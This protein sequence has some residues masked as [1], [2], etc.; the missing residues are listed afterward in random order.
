MLAGF[1]LKKQNLCKII[2]HWERN[3]ENCFQCYH[4]EQQGQTDHSIP[5]CQILYPNSLAG[6]SWNCCIS[7]FWEL[8][9]WREEMTSGC[10][11]QWWDTEETLLG[12][13]GKGEGKAQQA[14][15]R[16]L[17]PSFPP[18]PQFLHGLGCGHSSWLPKPFIP[19]STNFLFCTMRNWFQVLISTQPIT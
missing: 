6:R 11:N 15:T 17:C 2:Q 16:A 14:T 7:A 8:G 19:F 18:K 5:V 9:T 13:R 3:S 4:T 1:Q 10:W 12:S